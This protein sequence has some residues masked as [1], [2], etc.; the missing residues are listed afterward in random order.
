VSAY[1]VVAKPNV[2]FVR[3]AKIVFKKVRWEKI[4]NIEGRQRV[5]A[6]SLSG[7]DMV[8]MLVNCQNGL[9]FRLIVCL[10]MVVVSSFTL[11]PNTNILYYE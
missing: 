1:A 3:L 9:L 4:K 5:S 8:C 7:Y 10:S 2:P 6:Y 11:A